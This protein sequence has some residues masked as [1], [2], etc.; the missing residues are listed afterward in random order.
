MAQKVASSFSKIPQHLI[1]SI[2]E[3][4]CREKLDGGLQPSFGD[5]VRVFTRNSTRPLIQFIHNYSDEL[6][7]I[8]N[9]FLQFKYLF[10]YG[11]NCIFISIIYCLQLYSI[12]ILA[13]IFMILV[14]LTIDK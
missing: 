11:I 9:G 1:P 4:I 3:V 10:Q 12:K 14:I 8:F 13:Q 5:I 6:F 7:I 2:F